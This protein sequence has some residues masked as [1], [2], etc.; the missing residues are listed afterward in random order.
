[1]EE[2][3]WGKRFI[4][5][6]TLFR[7]HKANVDAHVATRDRQASVVRLNRSF[8]VFTDQAWLRLEFVYNPAKRFYTPLAERLICDSRLKSQ[9]RGYKGNWERFGAGM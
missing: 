3:V 8:L 7:L 5:K 1:M 2:R 6:P 4:T 9:E